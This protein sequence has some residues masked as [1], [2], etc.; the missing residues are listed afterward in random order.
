MR[1]SEENIPP[2]NKMVVENLTLKNKEKR[3]ELVTIYSILLF[4]IKILRGKK[5]NI[6]WAAGVVIR[7]S[8]ELHE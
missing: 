2:K 6:E 1:P 3:R 4:E 8:S 7:F 5:K